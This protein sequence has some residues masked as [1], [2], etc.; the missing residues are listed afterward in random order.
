MLRGTKRKVSLAAGATILFATPLVMVF[1][2]HHR[3]TPAPSITTLRAELGRRL[4]ADTSLS[5]DGTVSCSSCH[6]PSRAYTDG[7]P[8]AIGTHGQEGTR[9]TPSLATIAPSHE[10][11]FFWEGRRGSLEQAVLDPLT[12]PREMGLLEE[13]EVVR[14]I[15]SNPGYREPFAK[16]FPESKE[17]K[18]GNVGTALATFVQSLKPTPSTYDRFA[19]QN[20]PSALT[21]RAL[22]GL[23]L[24]KGK[25]GCVECHSLQGHPAMLTDH[26]YH[27]TG[28]G[29]D[30]VNQNLASLSE[31]VVQRS[32]EGGAVG[33]RITEHA[34]E[35]QLGR[36]NVTRNPSDIGLFRTP[37]LR[38]VARTAPYMHD[39]S[40][41]TLDEAIDREVYYR[42]LQR[43]YPVSLSVEERENL[44]AFLEAL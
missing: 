2:N 18:I 28:V 36:F 26:A 39:G 42:S 15:A 6:I 14:R 11:S 13:A 8:V 5:E 16:A 20:D 33:N 9:N 12:N 41:R 43:G 19:D 34:D 1:T 32:L 21:P 23:T 17:I 4:F 31:G 10:D 30:S 7:R 35:A 29:L 25:A 27:R 24:F 37:S 3:A 40:V 22:A 44:K 38:D